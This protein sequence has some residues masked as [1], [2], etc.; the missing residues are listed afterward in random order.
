[1]LAQ[2]RMPAP[3]IANCS[4]ISAL[5]AL[6]GPLTSIRVSFAIDLKRPA[7]RAGSSA[8]GETC[9]TNEM[10]RFGRAPMTGQGKLDLG[11]ERLIGSI[12][13]KC[14][15]HIVILGEARRLLR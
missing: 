10:G 9:V 7:R 4:N 13:R 1:V 12:R 14:V 11:Q 3:P 15:D 5:S 2:R 6:T 8:Q